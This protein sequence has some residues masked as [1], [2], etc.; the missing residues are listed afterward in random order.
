MS[1]LRY[2]WSHKY[3]DG[4]SKDYVF[5]HCAGGIEDYGSLTDEGL[6]ELL[7]EA[8]DDHYKDEGFKSYLMKKVAERLKVK[9]REK[10]LTDEEIYD[11]MI[12]DCRS[13]KR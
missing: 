3:V 8:I 7:C 11:E 4:K 6:V 13:V 5:S 2:A 10:P 9:L 1:Y 12:K